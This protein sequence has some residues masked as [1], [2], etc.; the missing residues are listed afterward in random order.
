MELLFKSDTKARKI[1][2]TSESFKHPAKMILP[3]QVWLIKK[4][5]NPGDIILDPMAGSGTVLIGT[6]LDRN[7]ICVELEEKFCKIIE[8]NWR[9]LKQI[10]L[11]AEYKMGWAKIL[12][13]DA[14][15]LEGVLADTIITSPPYE[16]TISDG[17]EGPLV[18]AN[19]KKYGRRKDGTA[20]LTSYTQHEVPCKAEYPYAAQNNKKTL[21]ILKKKIILSKCF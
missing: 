20:K 2:F 3:L 5:T 11:R 7:I 6:L 1:C 19:I 13:G 8:D 10:G 18:G 15:N 4:Y 12:Q 16:A 21:A 9:K 14:R 17:G